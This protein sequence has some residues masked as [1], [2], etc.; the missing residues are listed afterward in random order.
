MIRKKTTAELVAERPTPDQFATLERFPL[1]VVLDNV[2]S[3]QNVGL[4]FRL[5]DALR[6]KKLFLTGFTGYPPA[7]ENDPRPSNIQEHAYNQIAKT[8]I[9]LVPFV[10]WEYRED[11]HSVLDQLKREGVQI[12]ALEQT[13]DASTYTDVLYQFPVAL[14]IG[15]E[16]EGVND[17]VL[18]KCD[19][20]VEIPMFGIGNSLNLAT[21]L[22]VSGY[23]LV[24]RMAGK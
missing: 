6:V 20:V 16:R 10:D 11:I 8:G 15:H 9:K 4:V 14:V 1:Y 3:L 12:V 2:R 19:Q 24:K 17:T 21:A 13:H 18:A 23:E 22:A 7:G 5:C